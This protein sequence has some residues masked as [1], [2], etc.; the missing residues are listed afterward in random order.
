MFSDRP[1]FCQ[2]LQFY[3]QC[4]QP[5]HLGKKTDTAEQ[6]MRSRYSAY[7][8]QDIAYIVNTTVPAQ[9]DLLNQ[10]AMLQWSKDTEWDGLDII[11]HISKLDKIHAQ[12]EFKAYYLTEHGRDFHHEL[13][14]FVRI[15]QQWYFLDPTVQQILS[16]KQPCLCGSAKKFKYCCA[17]FLA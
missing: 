16:M 12:V 8:L 10:A 17:P 2:S 9:Q 14:A 15:G 5:Y 6:L 13:S 4:C 1:C 3:S 7:V 11:R